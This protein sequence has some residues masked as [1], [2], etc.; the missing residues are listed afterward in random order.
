[1]PR[2]ADPARERDVYTVARLNR[3]VRLLLE[4]GIPQVWIEA[5]LSNF[6]RPGSGHWYFTLKD[7]EAQVRCA[8]FRQRNMLVRFVPRDGA[9]VLARARVGLYEPRG[10]YQ[11]IVEHLE[12]AGLGALRREFERLKE[13]LAAEGLFAAEAKRPLPAVPRR[14]GVVTSPTGA[15]IR[16]ILHIL[17]RRFPAADVL[18]YPTAV[19][20]AAAVPEILAAL[21]R[22]SER[23]ECD[24]LIV[25]RGGGSLEDLW[26]FNDERVAR[27]IR[28]CP[29]PVVSGVGHEVDFTIADL[30]ADLR[31]PTP[32]GAAE[33][34]VPDGRS[35]L[36]ALGQLGERFARAIARQL[37]LDAQ[38]LATLRH[39]LGRTDPRMRLQQGAQRLDE[40]EQRLAA[41]LQL[42]LAR[43]LQ[44][45]QELR[46]R[47]GS[48][49]PAAR[50][51][52]LGAREASLAQRLRAA[53]LRRLG[54]AA[55]RLAVAQHT[56]HAVSPLAT[57]GRG[58]A[59][60]TRE[61]DGALVRSSRQLVAGERIAARLGAG[62]VRAQ[63][64]DSE[65]PAEG[66]DAGGSRE[67]AR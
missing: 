56:L 20:G 1:M 12:E 49:S 45:V 7:R 44:R 8:M 31:A 62:R 47:L 5:E 65:S 34:V 17:A 53:A 15:A 36:R 59:I 16:D 29:M 11:L 10:E 39:R 27:A 9:Q 28:A 30:V 6:A 42:R 55:A 4:Q 21:A 51:A 22:A 54:T 37:Q 43:S 57:L 67:P 66:S 52:R 23:R 64:L 13:K 14:I 38:R 48:A 26:A 40:L 35:W 41:P 60:V 61:R 3:E 24:V 2:P 46:A 32:S 58:F 25:A 63:V 18:I 19:Q 50:L 33:L